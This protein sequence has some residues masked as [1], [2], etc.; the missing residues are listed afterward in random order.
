M[1]SRDK[2][3]IFF[4]NAHCFK[5]GRTYVVTCYNYHVSTDRIIASQAGNAENAWDIAWCSFKRR[6]LD[7]LSREYTNPWIELHD[8]VM[9]SG[10]KTIRWS[11]EGFRDDPESR[12]IWVNILKPAPR[13]LSAV[14]WMID[15]LMQPFVLEAC[16]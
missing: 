12:H 8:G 16:D 14:D 3:R 10:V 1:K 9:I 15:D 11:W 6:I 13:E 7:G 5:V 4:P 2:F